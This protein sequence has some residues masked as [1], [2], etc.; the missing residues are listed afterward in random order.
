MRAEPATLMRRLGITLMLGLLCIALQSLR[1]P[2]LSDMPGMSAQ[3]LPS[4]VHAQWGVVLAIA[5]I[6]RDRL[7]LIGAFIAIFVG[8]LFRH[9]ADPNASLAGDL[10]F[11]AGHVAMYFA[12]IGCARL[13]GWPRTGVNQRLRIRDLPPYILVALLLYP[14]LHAAVYLLTQAMAGRATPANSTIISS[15]MGNV[16][17]ARHFGVL[18]VTL[19]VIMLWTGYRRQAPIAGHIPWW[20]WLLPSLLVLLMGVFVANRPD[21]PQ[22]GLAAIV[23]LRF[24]IAALLAWAISRLPW[25]YSAPLLA[26]SSLLLVGAIASASSFRQLAHAAIEVTSLQMML[27]YMMLM[28]RDNRDA[29]QRMAEDSRTDGLS[30]VPN[31]N[32]LRHDLG[33]R[34]QCPPD[35]GFLVI[36]R[37]EDMTAALGLPAQE[38][39]T[40]ALHAHL[41]SCVDAYTLGIGRF[42]LMPRP[43]GCDWPELLRRLDGFAFEYRRTT[44][45]IEPFLGIAPLG[46][47]DALDA[48]LHGAYK[49]AQAARRRG[50]L[51][52]VRIA[53]SD[54]HEDEHKTLRTHSLALAL[55]RRRRIV[56]H[57]Q[58]LRRIDGGAGID[59]GEVLCRLRDEDGRLLAPAEFMP[60]LEASRGIVELDRAVVELLLDWMVRH[61]DN[62]GYARLSVNLTGRSLSSR[63]FRRWLLERID[64]HPEL[65]TRLCFELTESAVG[66]EFDQARPLFDQLGQ[67][68]CWIALDD[69][70]TGM[71]SFERLQHLHIDLLKIDGTFVRDLPDNRRDHDFVQAM[72]AI[73][74]ACD[75]E[76][77]AEFVETPAHLE[78][79][80]Q[81]GVQWGQGYLFA[82]PVPLP[83]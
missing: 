41:D 66:S 6:S 35:I 12:T 36:D 56:L 37:V 55:L 23:D 74:R 70:G 22:R 67:R 17:L 72:V 27:V 9:Q 76:T 14:A 62:A 16:I 64:R 53:A 1:I 44:L 21:L 38:A 40:S 3:S 68:G 75:A 34:A 79:L 7:Y 71:Q 24:A 69:F 81:M 32:A 10:P 73:A 78:L 46:R 47:H 29:L 11:L 26:A 83:E 20:E 57:V 52:P 31:V 51:V 50:E 2:Y 4:L 15:V 18:V 8:W 59:M 49:A 25:R 82:R 28:A 63:D 60:E 54:V 30:G 33:R 77:V 19:P 39:L 48:A 42:A 13:L 5:L 45:H 43:R 61:P 58:T 65:A 80:R